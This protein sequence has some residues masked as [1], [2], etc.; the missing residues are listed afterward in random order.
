MQLFWLTLVTHSLL[1]KEQSLKRYLPSI[2]KYG[3]VVLTCAVLATLIGVYLAK[4]QGAVLQASSTLYINAGLIGDNTSPTLSSNDGIGLAADYASE[5]PSR[6]VMQAVYKSTPDIQNRGYSADDLLV[7]ITASSSSTSPTVSIIASTSKA[8]DS[9]AL[10]NDVATGFEAYILAQNQQ[11]LKAMRDNLQGQLATYQK[12]KLANE[13]SLETV[14]NNTDPHYA[15]YQAELNDTIHNIDAIQSQLVTLPTTATSNVTVIQLATAKDATSAV[16]ANLV[17]A[18][19]AGVGLLVGI[20]VMLLL[21]FLDN[22]LHSEEEIK[23]KLGVAYLGSLSNNKEQATKPANLQGLNMRQFAD[24]CA[25]LRLTGV[26][27]DQ[28]AMPHAATLLVTSVRSAEGK[29]STAI[30]LA[31]SLAHA[32]YSIVIVDAHLDQSATHLFLG[33]KPSGVGLSGLLMAKGTTV[34]DAV[35][36]TTVPNVWLLPGGNPIQ[37]ASLFLG[38][39]LPTILEQLRKKADVIIIDGPSLLSGAE[40]TVVANMV[41]GVLMVVDSSRTRFPLL[42]RAK[43]IIASL[44]HARVGVV[45]NRLSRKGN[46]SYYAS[47]LSKDVTSDKG[48]PTSQESFNTRGNGLKP[49]VGLT[50]TLPGPIQ[51]SLSLKQ[52]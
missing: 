25:N 40:A 4:G 21:I 18:A 52:S 11:R 48:E 2:K 16:K 37:D 35:Q 3:W 19:T 24:I 13:A 30:G 5:I 31:A 34:D 10:A 6:T 32:G 8:S 47:A 23:E 12:Q 26:L 20:L 49:N 22:R 50:K 27:P 45:L 41:D 42:L 44:A 36:R 29:T 14:P 17:L 39:R 33:V 9:A 51:P 46:D 28:W 15:V 1:W 7:D 43:E 38:K